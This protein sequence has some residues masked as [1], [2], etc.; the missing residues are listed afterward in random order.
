MSKAYIPIM[1]LLAI[2]CMVGVSFAVKAG[3]MEAA[4]A[5]IVNILL[6]V[7]FMIMYR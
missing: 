2:I 3:N 6:I 7:F 4:Y 1:S 5:F